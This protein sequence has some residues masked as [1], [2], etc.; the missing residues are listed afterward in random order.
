[1]T[2][3]FLPV[4]PKRPPIPDGVEAKSEE[5]T[6]NQ[7]VGIGMFGRNEG[8]TLKELQEA[9]SEHVAKYKAK[10][11]KMPEITAGLTKSKLHEKWRWRDDITRRLRAEKT[12][13][14][15]GGKPVYKLNK[16]TAGAANKQPKAAEG[17][18]SAAQINL[19]TP[20][21]QATNTVTTQPNFRQTNPIQ[22]DSAEAGLRRCTLEGGDK[23][24]ILAPCLLHTRSWEVHP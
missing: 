18:V 24:L 9:C 17:D 16:P 12:K 7:L 5:P 21:M 20:N 13:E 6:G 23:C 15:R 19:E 8:A 2:Q 3:D 14:E 11:S 4:P 22:L 1:M 10:G